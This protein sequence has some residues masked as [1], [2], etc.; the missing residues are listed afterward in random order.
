M[1]ASWSNSE[2][3]KVPGE[4]PPA[5]STLRMWCGSSVAT[6]IWKVDANGYQ[7]IAP[8]QWNK[9]NS[10]RWIYPAFVSNLASW[11]LINAIEPVHIAGH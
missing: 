4:S 5:C 9:S 3:V 6:Q 7:F 1:E 11:D 2:N 8:L 10:G